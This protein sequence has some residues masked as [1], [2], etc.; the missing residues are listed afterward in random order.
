MFGDDSTFVTAASQLADSSLASMALSLPVNQLFKGAGPVFRIL[1]EGSGINGLFIN[2][3]RTNNGAALVAQ[4]GGTGDALRGVTTGKGR[5]GFF[6][7]LDPMNNSSALEASTVGTGPAA[8]FSVTN[9]IRFGPAVL[10]KSTGAA[11]NALQ[12]ISVNESSGSTAYFE[13]AATD[14]HGVNAIEAYVRHTGSAGVFRIDGGSFNQRGA[15]EATSNSDGPAGL[16][17]LIRP[18]TSSALIVNSVGHASAGQFTV[19]QPLS[20]FAAIDATTNT[21]AGWAGLFTTTGTGGGVRITTNG[22]PGLQVL[23]GTKNAVVQTSDG[24]RALYTAESA[25]VWFTDS[26]FARLTRGFVRVAIDPVFSETISLSEPYHVFL[27]SYGDAE[28]IVKNRSASGFDVVMRDGTDD[29]AEFSYRIVAKR[30]GF[31]RERLRAER[32]SVPRSH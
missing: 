25:E 4:S 22:G 32:W 15:I 21:N 13:Q 2:E 24:A 6:N 30:L 29:Y 31:E 7:V 10:I 26:G 16:F 19:N 5:A 3:N 17:S 27:Q 18:S 20:I 14:N 23:G 12:V 8:T 1:H 9:P 11:G 28:L